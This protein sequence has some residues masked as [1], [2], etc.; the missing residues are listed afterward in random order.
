MMARNLSGRFVPAAVL[1]GGL[2]I[3]GAGAFLVLSLHETP[4][5]AAGTLLA[6]AIAMS[7]S[8]VGQASGQCV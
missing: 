7:L 3:L 1:L 4:R 2:L 5:G 6:S 8:A